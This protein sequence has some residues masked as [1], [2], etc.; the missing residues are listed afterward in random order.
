MK[1]LLTIDEVCEIAKV[2]KPTIYRRVKQGNFPKP[3]KVKRTAD[4]GPKAI[5]RWERGEVMGWLL[6]G[7]DPN[8]MNQPVK[9]IKETCAKVD[10]EVTPDVTARL[11]DGATDFQHDEPEPTKPNFVLYA[12]VAGALSALLWAWVYG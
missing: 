9:T 3:V 11:N 12:V 5:N 8:W 2:S 1:K 10:G 4:R 6:K 7:N